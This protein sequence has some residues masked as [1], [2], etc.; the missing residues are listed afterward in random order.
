MVIMA[1]KA[2]RKKA[3]NITFTATVIKNKSNVN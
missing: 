1:M 2:G 3:K